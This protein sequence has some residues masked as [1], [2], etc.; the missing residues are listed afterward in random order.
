MK[1]LSAIFVILILGIA[2]AS[3]AKDEEPDDEHQKVVS[4]HIIDDLKDEIKGV[5]LD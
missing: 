5:F 2:L 4:T 3:C 1:K